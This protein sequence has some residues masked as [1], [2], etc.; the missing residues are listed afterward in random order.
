M[1]SV[2]NGTVPSILHLIEE[3]SISAPSGTHCKH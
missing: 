1:K 2:N 3:K